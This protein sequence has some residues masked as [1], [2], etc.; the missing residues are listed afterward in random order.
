MR[1]LLTALSFA[2]VALAAIGMGIAQP[3]VQV[4]DVSYDYP[5]NA[6]EDD[7]TQRFIGDIADVRYDFPSNADED[8]VTQRF[9]GQIADVRY[10]YPSNEFDS[11]EYHRPPPGFPKV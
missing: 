4:A 7:V 9:V 3:N 11:D 8:D 6:E 2:A 5:S 1:K 10:D